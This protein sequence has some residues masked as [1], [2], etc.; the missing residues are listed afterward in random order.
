[1][2]RRITAG[3]CAGIVSIATLNPAIT[4]SS[5]PSLLFSQCCGFNTASRVKDE[6]GFGNKMK[7]LS[8]ITGNPKPTTKEGEWKLRFNLSDRMVNVIRVL[9]QEAG[10][11]EPEINREIGEIF[12]CQRE[13]RKGAQYGNWTTVEE[14]QRTPWYRRY[15]PNDSH[16][17]TYCSHDC[18]K[19]L[20]ENLIPPSQRHDPYAHLRKRHLEDQYMTERFSEE[21][22]RHITREELAKHTPGM[23]EFGKAGGR[24]AFLAFD[25]DYRAKNRGVFVHQ[26]EVYRAWIAQ[27]S[28]EKAGIVHPDDE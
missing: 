16:T 4:S 2:L 18:L 26:N 21:N 19:I 10:W 22:A 6:Y 15:R 5:S 9:L 24:A 23:S 12:A 1:M 27:K 20:E 7:D 17:V 11:K 14:F 13:A 8:V 28:K 3:R 25:K